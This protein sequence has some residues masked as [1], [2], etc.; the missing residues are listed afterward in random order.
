[1]ARILLVDRVPFMSDIT[2]FAL[3]LGGHSV[4]ALATNGLQA[5]ELYATLV[6]DLVITEIILQRYNGIEVLEKL[7]LINPDVKVIIC[8]AVQKQEV[9]DRAM[10]HGA[11]S[12]IIKPFQ[13]Q[14]FLSE[15]MRV[16]GEE[17]PETDLIDRD[18]ESRTEMNTMIGKIMTKKASPEEINKFVKK[19]GKGTN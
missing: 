1:M 17:K 10:A 11:E 6:P 12:Y 19:Y 18:L 13:I 16:L 14:S 7:K 15:I 2:K 5:I 3:S 8:T 4:V 9:I